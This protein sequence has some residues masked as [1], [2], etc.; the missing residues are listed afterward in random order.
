MA[1]ILSHSHFLHVAFV[2]ILVFQ[3][4]DRIIFGTLTFRGIRWYVRW[5][6]GDHKW[7]AIRKRLGATGIEA[8]LSNVINQKLKSFPLS[9]L[10]F[11][12]CTTADVLLPYKRKGS[13]LSLEAKSFNLKNL[14]LPWYLKAVWIGFFAEIAALSCKIW[15]NVR[16][17]SLETKWKTEK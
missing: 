15:H 9:L 7:Y 5:Q 3:I 6:Y 11:P 16:T 2:S 8:I 14:S 4:F 13:F 1:I 12:K 17:L 10:I